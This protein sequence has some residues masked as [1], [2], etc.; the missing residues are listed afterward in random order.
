[1]A[2]RLYFSF[3]KKENKKDPWNLRIGLEP[4]LSGKQSDGTL[5]F[6]TEEEVGFGG[7]ESAIKVGIKNIV[8]LVSVQNEIDRQ[9]ILISFDTD[10]LPEHIKS[11]ANTFL[12]DSV[13]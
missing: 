1:M 13:W 12:K 11:V 5:I 2:S 6:S 9:E 10:V 3:E 8:R 4:F 7:L